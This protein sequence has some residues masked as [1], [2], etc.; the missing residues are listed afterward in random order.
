MATGRSAV[1]VSPGGEAGND[2]A[3]ALVLRYLRGEARADPYP[4]LHRIRSA[5]PVWLGDGVLVLSSHEQ[6][7]AALRSGEPARDGARACPHAPVRLRRLLDRALDGPTLAGLAP[8]ARSVVDDRLD[9]VAARG[10]LEVV[11][12][13]AHPVPMAVLSRLLGLP[14]GDAPWLH[15][16]LRTLG[17]AYDSVLTGAADAASEAERRRAETDVEAY[18]AEVVRGRRD[19]PGDDLLSRLTGADRGG[20]RLTD[21]AAASAGRLLLVAGYET[22]AALVSG[23]VLALLRAPHEGDALRRDPGHARRLVEETLRVDPPLQVVR[24]RAGTDLE[25]CGVRVPRGTEMVLLLA[26][27]HRDP[28]RT[29]HPDV[30]APADAPPHMAFGAGAHLCPG[31]PPARLIAQTVLVRFAQRVTGARFA[32]GTPSY[33][34]SAALRGLRA[35]W[36]DAEGIAARDLPWPQ[37]DTEDARHPSMPLFPAEERKP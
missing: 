25:L 14:A 15:R 28:D 13:L 36:V 16:R 33:R 21:A 6:C 3:R 7:A 5:G 11:S 32:R 10:R 23:S 31:A 1:H 27:A 17:G 29:A 20:G 19:R 34:R 37:P 18:L 2:E 22:T 35:L 24:R 4:L 12:D 26:A 8:V 30:F 9:S